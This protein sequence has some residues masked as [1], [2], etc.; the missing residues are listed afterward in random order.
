[1]NVIEEVKQKIQ[2]FNQ[3]IQAVENDISATLAKLKE[4]GS[5]PVSIDEFK[6]AILEMVDT[7]AAM[8][9]EQLSELVKGMQYRKRW[10][11]EIG[12]HVLD[13][14]GH[15]TLE[16]LTSTRNQAQ[17]GLLMENREDG[18]ADEGALCFYFGDVVKSKL[19]EAMN[20][21][22]LTWPDDTLIGSNRTARNKEITQHQ[23][24]LE[25]LQARKSELEAGRYQIVSQL[26]GIGA[27]GGA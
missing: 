14:V 6:R 13:P 23:K 4:L 1:M 15:S 5:L 11:R 8:Y 20:G 24:A 10:V 7:K 18:K 19:L 2:D 12:E 25:A 16:F 9:Q 26:R 21:I 27:L 22:D 17:I 3:E